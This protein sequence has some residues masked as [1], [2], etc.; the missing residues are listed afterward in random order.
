M[1]DRRELLRT[2]LQQKI[3]QKNRRELQEKI[4]AKLQ[5]KNA[6]K[7]RKQNRRNQCNDILNEAKTPIV[8]IDPTRMNANDADLINKL[9]AQHERPKSLKTN[10]PYLIHTGDNKY[11]IVKLT[12]FLIYRHCNPIGKYAGQHRYSVINDKPIGKGGNASLFGVREVKGEL[13]P[14]IVNN[15]AMYSYKIKN[16][17]EKVRVCKIQVHSERFP[18]SRAERELAL[19]PPHLHMKQPVFQKMHL[20]AAKEKNN[21][22][23]KKEMVSYLFMRR[24][25]GV[26]LHQYLSRNSYTDEQALHLSIAILQAMK[27]QLHQ[28]DLGQVIHRDLKPENIMVHYDKN[29]NKWTINIID[30]GLSKFEYENDEGSWLVGTPLFISPEKYNNQNTTTQADVYAAARI[31]SE[32]YGSKIITNKITQWEKNE[33]LHGMQ[34][35]HL[36]HNMQIATYH[37]NGIMSLINNMGKADPSQRFT[38]DEALNSL[39]I[40]EN[41]MKFINELAK[42]MAYRKQQINHFNKN[43]FFNE[44]IKGLQTNVQLMETILSKLNNGE[45]IRIPGEFLFV[46]NNDPEL[47]TIF[48]KYQSYNFFSFDTMQPKPLINHL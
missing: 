24:M 48:N 44:Q 30:F 20:N 3:A 29:L 32:I 37:K 2:K 12:H 15:E 14:T 11:L 43:N 34:T 26:S 1:Q 45:E 28:N 36:F 35:R 31:L 39:I 16:R 4:R 40:I 21:N 8:E 7:Q 42:H 38:L 13:V 41:K 6:R 33:K 27:E 18:I 23:G 9:I 46:I 47:V 10:V 22:P 17:P 25:P 19:T 5:E